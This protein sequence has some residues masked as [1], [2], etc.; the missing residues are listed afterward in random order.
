MSVQDLA[1]RIR[2]HD[3][4]LELL[5]VRTPREYQ[6]DGHIEGS[7]LVP[8]PSLLQRTAELPKDKT[9]VC[10]CRSG[11][12]SYTAC[13]MLAA[14]GYDVVNLSGGMIGWRMAGLPNK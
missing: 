6:F 3:P 1:E 8:L 13:E 11:N 12:R 2:R 5:D 4:S 7:R 9:I 14:Q 10:I